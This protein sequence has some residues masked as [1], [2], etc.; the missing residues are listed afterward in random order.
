[1]DHPDGLRDPQ[2]YFERLVKAAPKAWTIAE[3]ILMPDEQLPA[4]WPIAGTTGYDFLNRVMRLFIDPSGEGPLTE[5]YAE[6]TV[7]WTDSAPP[8]PDK[9]HQVMREL[10][11]TNIPRLTSQLA[12]I[13]EQRRRYRDYTR[14][15]LNQMLREVIA[16]LAVYRT[17]VRAEEGVVS[18]CD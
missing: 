11:A 14:R 6:F 2:Q 15:E 17:Y 9:K 3:K 4:D 1:I 16:N 18:D 7:E 10:S 5:F 8:S 12:E 13:C